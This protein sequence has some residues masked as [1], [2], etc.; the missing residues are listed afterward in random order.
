MSFGWPSREFDGFDVL[1]DAIDRA[2]GMKVLMFAA[3]A[4][5]GG[6]SGRAYP[7]CSPHVI[8]VHSTDTDGNRS[9]FSPTAE[10]NAI[11]IATVGESV[12]SAWPTSLCHDGERVQTRSGTS[13]ATPIVVGI[14]AFLLHYVR[15]YLSENEAKILKRKEKMEALLRG[16]AERGPYYQPRDGYLSVDLSLY[17]QNLFGQ[18]D[19]EDVRRDI[20]KILRL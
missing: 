3:A 10:P 6:R 17:S 9:P 5:N 15:L 20:V 8:C 11:N 7:A 16:C 14:S 19:K 13:Y 1:E 18:K 2:Y 12:T 4:N